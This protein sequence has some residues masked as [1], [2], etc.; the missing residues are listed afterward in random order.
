M[1]PSG[2]SPSKKFTQPQPR[3]SPPGYRAARAKVDGRVQDALFR[4]IRTGADRHVEPLGRTAPG[5]PARLVWGRTGDSCRIDSDRLDQARREPTLHVPFVRHR[6]RIA[7]KF[8]MVRA[9][10]HR[11]LVLCDFGLPGR[12]GE[13]ELAENWRSA[14]GAA[15]AGRWRRGDVPGGDSQ[16]LQHPND[17]QQADEQAGDRADAGEPE[18]GP[19]G[20]VAATP[21]TA[22]VDG[23]PDE[24]APRDQAQGR[25]E[26]EGQ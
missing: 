2:S 20:R 3:G 5:W 21:L 7:Q 19:C 13:R 26:R 14:L 22:E 11:V 4:E 15:A 8:E 16:D 18:V 1:R 24:V 9:V 17:E 25:A 6:S 12:C 10:L 23:G